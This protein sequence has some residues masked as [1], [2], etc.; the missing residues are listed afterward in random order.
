MKVNL[1][2]KDFVS[3][4]DWSRDEL[5]TILDLAFELKRK[6]ALG[7][8]HQ[9]LAGKTLGMIFADDSLRHRLS[10]EAGMTQLG[11]HAQFLEPVKLHLVHSKES[12]EDTAKVASRYLDGLMIRLSRVSP[13]LKDLTMYGSA[14]E[15]QMQIAEY[16]DIPVINAYSDVEH[17]C[18]IMA[19]IMTLVEKFGCD[20]KN[21]KIAMVW[22]WSKLRFGPSCWNAMAVAAAKLGMTITFSYPQGFA[23][24]PEYIETSKK[25]AQ[26]SGAK[27]EFNGDLKSA[28]KDADVI[29]VQP[30]VAIGKPLEES[31]KMR[32]EYKHWQVNED[33]FK[34]A[35]SNALFMHDMPI[36]RGE[37]VTAEIADGQRSIIYDTAENSLHLQKAIMAML[38]G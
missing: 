25:L 10:F 6:L 18:Q 1:K 33:L 2:G 35:A 30:Q 3:L 4:L 19:N 32:A 23:F 15:L 36:R 29:Y 5:E 14:H 24:D 31:E 17:P 8:L 22:G 20:Y 28:C 12:W 26:E 7:E 34:V 13:E 37:E 16:A 21:K 9:I 11:G 38:M 27:I